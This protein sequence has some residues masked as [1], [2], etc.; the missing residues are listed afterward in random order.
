M[1]KY[2]ISL[3][4]SQEDEAWVAEVPD[5]KYCSAFGNSPEEALHELLIAL[6]LFLEVVKEEAR[7]LPELKFN[8]RHL[9][10]AS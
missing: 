9:A 5:L 3:F 8:P 2:A 4:Y 1:D 7:Q 6:R 10:A